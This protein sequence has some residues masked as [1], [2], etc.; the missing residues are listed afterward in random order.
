MKQGGGEGLE[1]ARGWENEAVGG[2]E[3]L[4]CLRVGR[5]FFLNKRLL[6]SPVPRTG[7]KTR[8]EKNEGASHLKAGGRGAGDWKSWCWSHP[9]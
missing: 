2:E 7:T 8:F 9:K 4:E 5:P 1:I 6:N 3:G